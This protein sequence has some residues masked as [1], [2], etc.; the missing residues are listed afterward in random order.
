MNSLLEI[1]FH[2][3]FN[4]IIY[5]NIAD[6]ASPLYYKGGVEY[7]ISYLS[8]DEVY[9]LMYKSIKANEDLILKEATKKN[10]SCQKT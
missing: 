1:M 4:G 9:N 3:C 8:I 2:D 7:N 10:R 6:K 5:Y